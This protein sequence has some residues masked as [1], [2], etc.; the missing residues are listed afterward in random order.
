MSTVTCVSDVLLPDWIIEEELERA[1]K[2]E[3]REQPYLEAPLP[4]EPYSR[5]EEPSN[6][7]VVIIPI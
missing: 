2:E 6:R 3:I 1:R 4:Q 5:A 7:G